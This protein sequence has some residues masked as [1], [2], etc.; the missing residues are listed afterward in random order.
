M[1]RQSEEWNSRSI[2][3]QQPDIMVESDTYWQQRGTSTSVNILEVM[4]G[5]FAVQTFTKEGQV[6]L[7]MDNITAV[8]YVNLLLM[9]SEC[10]VNYT[11]QC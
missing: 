10:G 11:A 9:T 4:A 6:H 8:A 5:V 3:I 2:L 7:K 1:D